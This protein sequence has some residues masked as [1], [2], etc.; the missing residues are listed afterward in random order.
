MSL[1]N[2]YYISLENADQKITLKSNPDNTW[3]IY[4]KSDKK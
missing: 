1:K 2:S 4:E 3:S